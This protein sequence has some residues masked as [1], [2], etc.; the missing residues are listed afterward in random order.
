MLGKGLYQ[1]PNTVGAASAA[2]LAAMT[3]W[4]FLPLD[5]YEL[6]G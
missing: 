2:K 1:Q 4:A 5:I 3:H 6:R